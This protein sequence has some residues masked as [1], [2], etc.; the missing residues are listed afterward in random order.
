[1]AR[2]DELADLLG[3]LNLI[4]DILRRFAETEPGHIDHAIDDALARIGVFTG[5]DRSYMFLLSDDGSTVDN[6]HEWCADGIEPQ[7]DQRQAIPTDTVA[8]WM[9]R[10]RVGEHLYIPSVPDLPPDRWQERQVLEPQHILSLVT[11]PLLSEGELIGFIGGDSTIRAVGPSATAVLGWSETERLGTN[12]LDV[13]H[14]EDHEQVAAALRASVDDLS[15]SATIPDHRVRHED[16]TW[17]WMLA[18]AVDLR[19][20]PIIDGIILNAHDIT[21]RKQAE[22]ALQHQAKHDP[23]TGLA[24]RTALLDRLSEALARTARIR[25]KGHPHATVAVVF[26]DI[27]RFNLINDSHGHRAGDQLLVEVGRRLRSTVRA[28]D[29]LARFGGDEFVVILDGVDD[30][31]EAT[32]ATDRLLDSLTEPFEIDGQRHVVTA[33]AGLV[34]SERAMQNSCCRMRTP[35]CPRRRATGRDASNSS[36]PPCAVT[37]VTAPNS[38]TTCTTRSNAG[39]STSPTSRWSTC[40]TV[41]CRGS[42]RCCGGCTPTTDRCHRPRSSRSPSNSV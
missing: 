29:T 4:T 21:S 26:L 34:L 9:P 15:Q 33:S 42:R 40:R 20:D 28:G 8:I 22:A 39:S 36:M 6:T 27:D 12:Y 13:V 25:A 18:T 35:R 10:L 19:D 16:G 38:A 32:A 11:V 41:G 17:R 7:I 2:T 31:E 23:L 24:N 3:L 30:P 14:R 1:M 37:S 5:V